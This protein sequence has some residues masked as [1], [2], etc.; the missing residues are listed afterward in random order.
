M[1]TA[2]IPLT[3]FYI[4][5]LLSLSQNIF[6]QYGEQYTEVGGFPPSPTYSQVSSKK[7]PKFYFLELSNILTNKININFDNVDIKYILNFLKTQI[8]IPTIISPQIPSKSISVSSKDVPI[9]NV[10]Q[11]ILKVSDIYILYDGNTLI[12][13]PYQEYEKTL[14]ENFLS[15]KVY[16]MKFVNPKEIK[17]I[18]K[19]Y[20][21]PLGEVI[22]D[23]ENNTMVVRDVTMNFENI[24]K[25][26][27]DVGVSPRVVMIKVD[28][29]QVDR[30]NTL[31]YGFDITLDNIIKGITSL[32]F[33]SA[34]VNVSGT[35]LFSVK[36]SSGTL[37]SGSIV[38]GLI[39]TLSTYGDVKL[40]SSPR[41]VCRN[42]QKAKILIGDKVPYVKSIIQEQTQ[43]STTT[44]QIDFIEAGIKLEVEPRIT[45]QGEISIDVKVG[46]S[47]YR[48]IELTS[49]LKSPQI[50]TTEGEIKAVVKDGVP[51]V[52]G[53]LEKTSDILKKSGI[54]FLMD[55]PILGDIFFA[56]ISKSTTR[57]TIIIVLTPEIIDYSIPRSITNE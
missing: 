56:N 35:G 50:N 23:I 22:I 30:N 8:P 3:T 29:I 17:E 53:G 1:N 5:L 34:P 46:I 44:S 37:E 31:D 43:T 48:F 19:P 36:F 57:S 54:P 33:Q 55:I 52:I 7:V 16:D 18:I 26:L 27:R 47:S 38:S 9:F 32:S 40:L 12:F 51:L 13:L 39:K 14:R 28:I 24:E 6:P 4:V 21:T 45:L 20:L 42:G 11:T 2:K 49:T 10:I 25:F 41:V 15:T